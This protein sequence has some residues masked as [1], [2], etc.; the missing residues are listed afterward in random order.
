M[1]HS[2]NNPLD[3][4]KKELFRGFHYGTNQLPINLLPTVIRTS[5]YNK[6]DAIISVL[7]LAHLVGVVPVVVQ[8]VVSAV[9]GAERLFHQVR[10]DVVGLLQVVDQVVVVLAGTHCSTHPGW[11]IIRTQLELY[12]ITI[13][14]LLIWAVYISDGCVKHFSWMVSTKKLSQ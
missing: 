10:A 14:V 13:D 12:L 3:F 11:R 5:K 6:D 7:G 4:I 1:L 2:I 8:V 9:D